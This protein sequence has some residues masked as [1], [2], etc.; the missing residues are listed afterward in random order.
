MMIDSVV[1]K[2]VALGF[3]KYHALIPTNT[4]TANAVAATTS[5]MVL[6]PLPLPALIL[7]LQLTYDIHRPGPYCF[8]AVL[9]DIVPEIRDV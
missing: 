1:P 8:E 6:I 4:I 2:E 7:W 3:V 9:V 5:L